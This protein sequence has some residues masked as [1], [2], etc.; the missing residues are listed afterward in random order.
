MDSVVCHYSGGNKSP[1]GE[2]SCP[3]GEDCYC[4][5]DKIYMFILTIPALPIGWIETYTI[6]SYV[7]LVGIGMA[8]IGML[9][10]FGLLSSEL[11]KHE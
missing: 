5:H 4:G 6:L 8:I 7:S 11:A 1:E 10:M 2:I 9:F 3:S